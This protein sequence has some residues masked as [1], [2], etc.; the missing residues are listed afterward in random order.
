MALCYIL[1]NPFWKDFTNLLYLHQNLL[2]ISFL[3]RPS[4]ECLYLQNNKKSFKRHHYF[5]CI[6]FRN[7]QKKRHIYYISGYFHEFFT[8][9]LKYLPTA[10]FL[11]N[12][13]FLALLSVPLW[14]LKKI[15]EGIQ[16]SIWS[17][18]GSLK[19]SYLH[20]VLFSIYFL[21]LMYL[22]YFKRVGPTI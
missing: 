19:G 3:C 11:D 7:F 13:Q 21:F 9:I 15:V 18:V 12:A 20:K 4:I 5:E 17:S 6:F 22:M 14:G 16:R 8:Y 2:I 1:Y 10:K